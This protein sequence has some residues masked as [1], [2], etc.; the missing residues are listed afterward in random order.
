MNINS[1]YTFPLE[2][3]VE[4]SALSPH[5]IGRIVVFKDLKK[6]NIEIDIV[7]TESGKIYKHVKSIYG[8]ED[9]QDALAS[10]IQILKNFLISKKH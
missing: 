2:H 7:Q 9:L 5:L 8:E 4:L 1:D 3:F 6:L 10:S